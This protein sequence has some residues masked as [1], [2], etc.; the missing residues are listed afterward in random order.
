M[1]IEFER[2]IKKGCLKTWRPVIDE[3]FRRCSM[4]SK[5]LQMINNNVCIKTALY[6][7]VLLSLLV[8]GIYCGLFE[9]HNSAD[10]VQI[11][12]NPAIMEPRVSESRVLEVSRNGEQLWAIEHLRDQ[13]TSRGVQRGPQITLEAS[14]YTCGPESTGKHKSDPDYCRTASGYVLRPGDKVA[15]MGKK[16]PFGTLVMIPGYGLATVKDR[17]GA[18]TDNHIDLYFEQLE[19]ALR[20]GR[21]KVTVTVVLNNEKK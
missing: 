12:E 3:S 11:Q 18:I 13:G 21:R 15:A 20:W 19:D 7:C 17:G 5:G 9:E 14:A 10:R 8:I 6:R 2:T 1:G 4:D 16:Y